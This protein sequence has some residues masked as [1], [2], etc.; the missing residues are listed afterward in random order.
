MAGS[1]RFDAPLLA[2]GYHF[3][4]RGWGVL[5]SQVPDASETG[6]PGFG[7]DSVGPDEQGKE[8]WFQILQ[9][10]PSGTYFFN[11]DTSFRYDGTSF[12]MPFSKTDEAGAVT[13]AEAYLNMG[14]AYVS[15]RLQQSYTI[16]ADDP[17]DPPPVDPPPVDP[18]PVDPPADSIQ[19]SPSRTVNFGGGTNRVA[20]DG[21]KN[22]VNF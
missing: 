3:G 8:I 19:V 10:P 6:F 2:D 16:L 5:G 20:F 9:F 13:Y 14:G 18:P 4:F 15:S 22:R 7:Y 17:T 11:E 12:V 1:Y 21:G